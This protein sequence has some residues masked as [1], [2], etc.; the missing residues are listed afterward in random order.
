MEKDFKLANS[1]FEFIGKV[2][3]PK[4][5]DY[6][7][8]KTLRLQMGIRTSDS[9]FVF[10]DL[11]GSQQD[12]LYLMN[13]GNKKVMV[14]WNDRVQQSVIESIADYKKVKIQLNP[15]EK[16]Q[17]FIS[18]YDAINSLRKINININYRVRGVINF[19][20]Y[21]NN[22]SGQYVTSAKFT[23]T[24]IV[25]AQD[26]ELPKSTAEIEFIFSKDSLDDTSFNRDKKTYVSAYVSSY[27]SDLKSTIF[28][29]FQLVINAEK[30][31]LSNALQVSSLNYNKNYFIPP[32]NDKYY[33]TR[34]SC[35]VIRGVELAD[36]TERDLTNEQKKQIASGNYTFEEIKIEMRGKFSKDRINE[37]RLLRPTQ[38]FADGILETKLTD[39]SF[40][41]PEKTEKF[42][43]IKSIPVDVLS[44]GEE[45]GSLF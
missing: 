39:S 16:I 18:V 43:D 6:S 28:V 44:T 21:I 31:D 15:N 26:S 41:I 37:I 23:P 1:S 30:V 7:E 9:N 2:L 27:D 22:S 29:P 8:G 40:I 13:K 25:P 45:D 10:V 33:A 38:K 34:W 17:E 14:L 3:Q 11:L 24:L 36:I 12:K 4:I 19:S 20:R 42:S 5:T 32:K 35:N